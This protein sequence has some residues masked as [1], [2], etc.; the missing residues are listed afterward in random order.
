ME[1][2]KRCGKSSCL[3]CKFVKEG[4]SFH[5]NLG[6][7]EFYV[8]YDF[9]CDSKGNVYVGSTVTLFRMRFNNH[10]SSL[11]WYGRGQRGIPGEHLYA[12]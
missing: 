7:K 4:R 5:N 9:D 2:L 3:I 12:H 11:M 10:K 6:N 1:G 8:N